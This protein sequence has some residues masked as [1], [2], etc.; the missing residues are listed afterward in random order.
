M[1]SQFIIAPCLTGITILLLGWWTVRKDLAAAK[2]WTGL[3]LIGPACFAAPLALF[4]AEHLVG[5]QFILPT[6][7]PWMPWRIFWV[8]FVGIA[9]IAA[10]VSIVCRRL[11]RLSAT[12]LSVMFFLFVAMVHTPRLLANPA[13]RFSWTVLLR[14]ISF[15]AGAW[16]LAAAQSVTGGPRALARIPRLLIAV[17]VIQFGVEHVLHPSFAPGVPLALM[18]PGWVPFPKLWGYLVGLILVA[19]GLALLADWKTRTSA[20]CIGAVMMLLTLFLY[21][22]IFATDTTELIRG[23]NYVADTL[24][25]GGAVLLLAMAEPLDSPSSR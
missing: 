6:V 13:D 18:T 19:A 25:F 4:G 9:L 21:V 8:Y 12:L 24:L 14:D 22:P 2:G 10:G 11:V 17:A 7:P 16:A 15:A 5:A 1:T 23:M 3:V 20:A